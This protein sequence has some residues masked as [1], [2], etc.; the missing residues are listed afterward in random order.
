MRTLVWYALTGGVLFAQSALQNLT[1]ESRPVPNGAE[2]LT[3]YGNLADKN[4]FTRVPLMA[5]LRDTLGD[6]NPENDK[7]RYVWVFTSTRPTLMQRGAAAIPFFYWRPDLGK[8][9]NNRPAPLVDLGAPTHGIYA[10]VATSIAQVTALDGNGV[11]L[12]ASSRRYQANVTDQR[13]T[14]L[15][16]GLVVLSELEKE[17]RGDI[18][19]T[20]SELFDTEARLTLAS[21]MLGGFVNARKL[22]EAY[23]K[24][25]TKAE[26]QRG[27]NWE[28]LRQRAESNGLYFESM[29]LPGQPSHAMLWVAKEDAVQ[30]HPFDSK[31]LGISN[32]FGDARIKNWSGYEV[33]RS[34]DASNRQVENGAPNSRTVELVPLALYS[35][36]YPKVPLLLADF[37]SYHSAKRREMARQA[38]TDTLTGVLGISQ[39]GNWPYL[40]G[41]WTWNFVRA[42]YGD[43]NNR[44][45][46]LQAYSSGRQWLLL[47]PKLDY[48]LRVELQKRLEVMGVNPL[49]QNVFSEADV[50]QKQY[51]ALLKYALDPK[52]LGVKLDKART[53]ELAADRHTF[54]ERAWLQFAKYASL[55]V[56]SHQ[57]KTQHGLVAEL[58]RNRRA[59]HQ[60]QFL[61]KV[62]ASGSQPEVVWNIDQVRHALDELAATGVEPRGV[63]VIQ[64]LRAETQDSE[65]KSLYEKTLRGLGADAGE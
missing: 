54:K 7:L 57:E 59:E 4:V 26:Q 19:L 17:P 49:E 41:S 1:V 30:N 65:A 37:R 21:Q 25:K 33:T 12:R 56:Y 50:A 47:D 40:A 63:Q 44:T 58:D 36:D 46:R 64:K 55:G 48:D 16:E 51:T 22:P 42:R 3:V 18:G 14:H 61:E 31:F 39:W 9:A 53:S 15:M 45:A 24:Q 10:A 38:I 23:R 29:G 13:K 35:L 60:I 28:L 27:H 5:V 34:Y 43:P 62:A 52:G 20:G 2:L 8:N 6:S 11:I 32:P